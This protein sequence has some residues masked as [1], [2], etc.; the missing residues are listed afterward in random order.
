SGA[1]HLAIFP[2]LAIV[3]AALGFTLFGERLREALD[4]KYRR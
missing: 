3:F 1:I 4:P 2:G